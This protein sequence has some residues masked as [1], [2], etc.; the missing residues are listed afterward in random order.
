MKKHLK[1]FKPIR[2]ITATITRGTIA[3]TKF[4]KHEYG[5]N[6]MTLRMTREEFVKLVKQ[7]L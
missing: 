4:T 5:S 7:V 6:T 1:D 3:I 2:R